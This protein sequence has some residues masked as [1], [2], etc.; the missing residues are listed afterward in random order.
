MKPTGA[1]G[2]GT[3]R[4][5][6]QQVGASDLGGSLAEAETGTDAAGLKPG[7][8]QGGYFTFSNHFPKFISIDFSIFS[9]TH[10]SKTN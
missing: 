5:T 6:Q 9:L 4:L 3:L 7:D 1:V 2:K 10:C 8:S